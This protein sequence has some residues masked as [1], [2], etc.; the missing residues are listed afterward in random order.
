MANKYIG[1]D[2]GGGLT[3]VEATTTS[4]GSGD[5][6]KIP[7]LNGAG[8]IDLTMMPTGIGP[9]TKVIVASES[10]A[11]GDWVNV[12]DVGGAF[13]A[14]KADATTTGKE[15]HGFVL[16]VVN[17]GSDATVYTAGVNT[18]VSAQTP[19]PVFLSTTAG[20]GTATA[21]SATGNVVQ[22]I[23]VAVSATSVVFN[24]QIPVT[25]S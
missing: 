24:P 15:A 14:R 20:R 25:L 12:H 7:A 23:G 2:G 5:S 21:P 13:R 6:G 1:L 10:L 17:S 9:D 16:A 22:R 3:E 19:G 4:S 8:Q 11:N 18:G